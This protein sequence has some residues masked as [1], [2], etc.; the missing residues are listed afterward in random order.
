MPTMLSFLLSKRKISFTH[1]IASGVD[2]GANLGAK[3][4]AA[5]R[6]IGKALLSI[7]LTVKISA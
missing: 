2:V 7:L 3:P 1:L 4:L 6:Y 5:V